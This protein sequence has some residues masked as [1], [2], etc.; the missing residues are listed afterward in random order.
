MPALSCPNCTRGLRYSAEL[1][2]IERGIDPEI[3]FAVLSKLE[4]ELARRRRSRRKWRSPRSGREV[5]MV[6]KDEIDFDF[7]EEDEEQTEPTPE[8]EPSNAELEDLREFKAVALQVQREGG[9]SGGMRS[10]R[11]DTSGS[12]PA[13]TALCTPRAKRTDPEDVKAFASEYGRSCP[14]RPVGYTPTTIG[15][16]GTRPSRQD[17]HTQLRWRIGQDNPARARALA[18]SGARPPEQRRWREPM[19]NDVGGPGD[20]TRGVGVGGDPE[21]GRAAADQV[22]LRERH[23]F[24]SSAARAD[25]ERQAPYAGQDTEALQGPTRYRRVEEREDSGSNWG[26][27]DLEPRSELGRWLAS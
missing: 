22:E 21:G 9:N 23:A 20:R 5:A 15:N 13:S 16:E 6:K 11:R 27:R 14:P 3:A 8:P 1:L 17:L 4:T 2:L 10:R 18:G 26:R 19:R 25:L 7:D 24:V 12:S